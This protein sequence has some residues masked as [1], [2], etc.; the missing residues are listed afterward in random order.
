MRDA[1]SK[2]DTPPRSDPGR[3]SYLAAFR[4]R[5]RSLSGEELITLSK[6]LRQRGAL[7]AEELNVIHEALDRVHNVIDDKLPKRNNGDG[8]AKR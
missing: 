8:G 4:Q 7:A 2:G 5:V 6:L 1:P 3:A